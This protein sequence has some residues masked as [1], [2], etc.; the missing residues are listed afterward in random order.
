MAWCTGHANDAP[1]T[2]PGVR[3]T[4]G[5]GPTPV[6]D[7]LCRRQLLQ[8]LQ[9]RSENRPQALRNKKPDTNGRRPKTKAHANRHVP[10]PHRTRSPTIPA[11]AL[12]KSSP[13]LANKTR[14]PGSAPL[15]PATLLCPDTRRQV[16]FVAIPSQRYGG[17]GALPKYA[18][19]QRQGHKRGATRVLLPE[20]GG[21]GLGP[22]NAKVCAPKIDQ[23]NISFCKI[24]LF[25]TAKTGCQTPT[26]SPSP[27]ETLSC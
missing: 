13:G 22:K 26:P 1:V 27:Q 11:L 25:P 18:G 12:R 3:S 21:G 16:L 19:E 14:A 23:I 8:Q 9:T 5:G 17:G 7:P 10:R 15:P 6:H 4:N 2:S 20:G 24:S